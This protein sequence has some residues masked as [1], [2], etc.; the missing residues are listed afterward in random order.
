MTTKVTKDITKDTKDLSNN[1]SCSFVPHF[2]ILRGSMNYDH[3]GSQRDTK[4]L[5]KRA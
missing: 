5:R 3:Y 4:D 1:P 2:V